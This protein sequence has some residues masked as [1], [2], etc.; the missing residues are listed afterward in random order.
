[1]QL[2]GPP[3][4]Y[5]GTEIGM[6]QAVSKASQVGLEASRMAMPWDQGQDA[7]LLNFY[8]QMIRERLDKK[9]WVRRP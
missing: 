2:P 9:P 8:K 5:Y 3:V 6:S 1:M 7:E 4:I